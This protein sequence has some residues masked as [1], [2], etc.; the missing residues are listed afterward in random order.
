MG[1]ALGDVLP[2]AIAVAVFPVPIVTVV[3]VLASDRGRSK[4]LGFVLAWFAGLAAVGIAVG[5]G[6]RGAGV[7]R[8]LSRG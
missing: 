7:A 6:L 4:G 8:G 3:I 5:S 1:Q 2:L